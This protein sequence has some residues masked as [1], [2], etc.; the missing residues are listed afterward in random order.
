MRL[1]GRS[2][3]PASL[4]RA[5]ALVALSA[6]V[7]ASAYTVKSSVE[8][9]DIVR[10]DSDDVYREMNKWWLLGY[11]TGRNFAMDGE[12]G[13]GVDDEDIY[14][15]ALEYCRGNAG[16]DWDDAAVHVYDRLD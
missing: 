5:A 10:E 2:F 8:C 3:V 9:P 14:R 12:A 11:I 4:V 7:P 1:Q 16:D 13:K 15:M 6:A